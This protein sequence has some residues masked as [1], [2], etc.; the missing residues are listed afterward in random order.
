MKRITALVFMLL[1][2]VGSV[3]FAGNKWEYLVT[4][5]IGEF[6]IDNGST[7]QCADNGSQYI[8][9]RVKVIPSSS[10][11][12]VSNLGDDDYTINTYVINKQSGE[13][14]LQAIER[15]TKGNRLE[16]SNTYPE[17]WHKP[18]YYNVKEVVKAVLED[19]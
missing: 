9:I 12:Y 14:Y 19:K 5:S 4:N 13:C 3:C 7:Q 15:Y 16:S 6:Y 8:K 18:G 2:V 1:L 10:I 17:K 11:K